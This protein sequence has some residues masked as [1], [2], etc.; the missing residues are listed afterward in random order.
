M[1]I[2]KNAAINTGVQKSLLDPIFTSFGYTHPEVGL[3]DHVVDLIFLGT[4]ILF[5]AVDAQVHIPPSGA[6][7]SLLHIFTNTVTSCLLHL[8][9][10]IS[11]S[12]FDLHFP[13]N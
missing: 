11:H 8:S 4:S 5:S 2:E 10:G 12:G 1:A 7:D 3:L 9:E 13:D 6:E